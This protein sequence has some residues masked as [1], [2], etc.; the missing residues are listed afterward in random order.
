V[1]LHNGTVRSRRRF[2]RPQRFPLTR[3][4]FRGQR[5]PPVASLTYKPANFTR[6]IFRLRD[7]PPVRPSG[8]RHPRLRPVALLPIRSSSRAAN[9][10]SPSGVFRSLWIKAF[11]WLP[12]LPV[13]LP[14]SP[15]LRSLPAA[16]PF[17]AWPRIT[18]PDPLHV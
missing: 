17:L 8:R 15:D 4:P 10:H 9:L 6:S 5:F 7:L 1:H 14:D 2:P 18:V 12:G 16:L 11:N 3:I 13:H